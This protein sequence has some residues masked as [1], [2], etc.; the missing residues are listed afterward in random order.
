MTNSWWL[1]AIVITYF[2]STTSGF[3]S[4]CTGRFAIHACFG[5]NGKRSGPPLDLSK[6]QNQNDQLLLKKILLQNSDINNYRI[7]DLDITPSDRLEDQSSG[8]NGLQDLKTLSALVQELI[9]RQRL[10]DLANG[11]DM[12]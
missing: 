11:V 12:V 2:S 8:Y 4:K 5:G 7:D 1:I 6:K 10:R 3:G 9:Y